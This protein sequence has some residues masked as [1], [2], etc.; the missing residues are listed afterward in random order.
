MKLANS[1]L[2]VLVV[3]AGPYGLSLAAHL[4]H[5]GIEFRIFGIPM[6]TW[7]T[8]MPKGM[9]LKSEGAASSL[10]DPRRGMTL[11]H[12]CSSRNVPYSDIGLPVPI[13]TFVD[14]G[15]AF[16]R[17]LVPHVE[18]NQVVALSERQRLFNLRLDTGEEVTARQVVIAVGTTYFGHLPMPF[19]SLPAELVSH[20]RHHCDFVKFSRMD[21]VVIG[22]GQSALETAAMLHEQ[23]AN[24]RVLVREP[25]LVWNP[26]PQE[27]PSALWTLL[28]PPSDLGAGWK[29]WFYSNAPAVFQ[30]FP[31]QLRANIVRS[32]L[33]PAGAWWLKERVEGRFPVSLGHVVQQA[34]EK[35]GKACLSVVGR[36][37]NLEQICADHV[38]A[39]TG[40]KVDVCSLPFLD[41]TL[42]RRMR[43]YGGAPVLSTNFES[44][45]PGLYF[46]GLAA[47]QQ[48]GPCLRF[49]AGADYAARK[50]SN[51]CRRSATAS[52]SK[53][54]QLQR[55]TTRS[56]AI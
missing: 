2:D 49:V 9:F 53:A 50:I 15:L 14:Y 42:V 55:S 1:I 25:M 52:A 22:G 35:A 12:Y 13:E 3:G 16:Q 31:Q 20:S 40:Y 48:F 45:I 43:V 54:G 19:A 38:L 46:T 24:V 36:D 39:G 27:K 7:R 18:Q 10:S 17:E 28:H 34:E 11:G 4:R 6:Q 33:G 56:Q 47:A 21:V 29:S 8:A 26:I 41:R 37:G 44:S 32:A 30:F 5:F 23:G 51:A